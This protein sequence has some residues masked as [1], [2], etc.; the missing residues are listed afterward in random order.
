MTD[1]AT[2]SDQQPLFEQLRVA[3]AVAQSWEVVH[4]PES[5][6][7]FPARVRAAQDTLKKL[8]HDLATVPAATAPGQEGQVTSRSSALLELR[9][10]FR[11]LR[12]AI[13]G[14]SDS[15]RE[16]AR[17]PR[18]IFKGRQEPPRVAACAEIY[19]N[20]VDGVYSPAT[21]RLFMDELQAYE[22]LNVRELWSITD[23][24]EF[25]LLESLL[26][27]ARI[28]LDPS[29]SPHQSLVSNRVRS[30]RT[31]SQIDRVSIIEPLIAIDATL[32]M[33]PAE[34]YGYMD[35]ESREVYRKRVAAIA[36]HSDH[37]ES[38]VAL[39]ALEL[40][41]EAVH[42]KSYDPRIHRRRMHVGYYLLDKGLPQLAAQ[43]GFH[44]PLIDRVRTSIRSIGDDFYIVGIALIS[45]FGIAAVLFPLLPTYSITA[46]A[47]AVAFLLLPVTQ[48][49]VDLVNNVV[50]N[51]FGPQP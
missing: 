40:A 47:F 37:S 1:S 22:P 10:N 30:L 6:S 32:R 50:T 36:L 45:I 3:T 38:K 13:N 33:D 39:T 18:V 14:V 7:T 44:P 49:A 51:I 23:F 29:T 17:L 26:A 46:L 28:L 20:A 11:L 24:L 27:E 48:N 2:I 15:P 9:E 4:R 12:S 25:V 42:H 8:E 43:V 21:F 35:F 41:R 31:I 5:I 19:L 34:A 16:V